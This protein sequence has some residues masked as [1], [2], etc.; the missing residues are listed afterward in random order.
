MHSVDNVIQ[1]I[2]VLEMVCSV[3]IDPVSGLSY[4]ETACLN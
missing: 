4:G 2:S 1:R 3:G